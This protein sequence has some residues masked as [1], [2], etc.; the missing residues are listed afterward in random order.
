[1]QKKYITTTVI[2]AILALA[3]IFLGLS[4]V[5]YPNASEG[6]DYTVSAIDDEYYN[7]IALTNPSIELSVCES[8]STIRTFEGKTNLATYETQGI[9]LANSI[10][11]YEFLPQVTKTIVIAIDRAQTDADIDSFEDLLNTDLEINFDFGNKAAGNLWEYPRTHQIVLT[12]AQAI[13]GEYDVESIALDFN[14]INKEG[15]FFTEDMTKP[16]IV[17]QDS[18]A[19]NLMKQGRDIE[20]I[21]PNDGTMSFNFGALM[22]KDSI[23]FSEETNATLVESG[24]RLTTKESDEAYYP[25]DIQYENAEYIEDLDE[26]NAAS[27]L[28]SKTLRRVGFETRLFGFTNTKEVATFYLF[29]LFGLILYLVTCLYRVT[30]KQ[31]RNV[32]VYML[33]LQMFFIS[34]GLFKSLNT[35][36]AFVETILWYAYYVSILFTPAMFVY[37]ALYSGNTKLNDKALKA[38]KLYSMMTFFMLAM[39]FT[40]SIHQ[41]VFVV[42]DYYT[43]AFTYNTGYY[44]VMS[45]VGFSV[46]FAY[47]LLAFKSFKSPKKHAML[48]PMLAGILVLIYNLCILLRFPPVREFDVSFATTMLIVL[49]TE[50]CMQSRFFPTNVGYKKLFMNSS[51][52]MEIKDID[53]ETAYKSLIAKDI[54]ENYLLRNTEIAGGE[55]YYFED[56]SSLNEAQEK[57]AVIID[58]IR[59]SNEF[60]MQQ[61]QV[62]ADLTTIA[63]EKAVYD[64]IDNIL[65]IGTDKIEELI[66]EMKNCDDKKRYM[67]TISIYACIMKRE[68]MFRINALY[69]NAQPVAILH[70]SL[71]ELS[72]FALKIGLKITI[73]CTMSGNV[74]TDDI[75]SIYQFASLAIE[76]AIERRSEAVLLQLYEERESFV[77]SVLADM[78]LLSDEQKSILIDGDVNYAFC[79]KAW[80]DTESYL[81]EFAQLVHEEVQYD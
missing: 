9:P 7:A 23:E 51:L 62:N 37:I 69:Q 39:V 42:S 47:S 29:L 56:Y 10:P 61:G 16:I 32:L 2:T 5:I 33:I 4:L 46:M 66:E 71:F 50:A 53:G 48:Y 44:I 57:L 81:L 18:T 36:N 21:I 45:W 58:E 74:P 26:F 31:I 80:E 64:N 54:D 68:C 27:V 22:R 72:E 12:M 14:A 63:A 67:N 76:R 34:S 35:T 15:R 38:Y 3:M 8:E 77:F 78:P 55:F 43:T 1:M 52:A 19:V 79:V 60:L 30:D 28:V 65:L 40:N 24:F 20:I 73:N 41:F 25:S 59:Q 49:Y 11:E 6:G 13:Y 75:L 17:T 70:R